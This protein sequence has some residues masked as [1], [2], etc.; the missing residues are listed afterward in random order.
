[1]KKTITELKK[2]YDSLHNVIGDRTSTHKIRLDKIVEM[3][4]VLSNQ[5][6]SIIKALTLQASNQPTIC[7]YGC[8]EFK[9]L[10]KHYKEVHPDE[11]K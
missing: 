11:N 2:E 1:M 8:G 3:I 4:I 10:M 5:I 6:Q 9:D 7:V